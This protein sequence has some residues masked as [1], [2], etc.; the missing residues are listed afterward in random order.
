[1]RPWVAFGL[2]LAH[3]GLYTPH[4]PGRT[5]LP[6]PPG[7]GLSWLTFACPPPAM[8]APG[9]W[10]RVPPPA[11]AAPGCPTA[12]RPTD[13]C[14]TA[15]PGACPISPISLGPAPPAL[16]SAKPALVL[17]H[18]STRYYSCWNPPHH[19]PMITLALHPA[20][21]RLAASAYPTSYPKAQKDWNKLEAEVK[22]RCA[23]PLQTPKRSSWEH[24]RASEVRGPCVP[25]DDVFLWMCT[26]GLPKRTA[27]KW[28]PD[29]DMASP[30]CSVAACLTPTRMRCCWCRNPGDGEEGGDGGRGPVEQLFQKD[31]CTGE[32]LHCCP[33]ATCLSFA[34]W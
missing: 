21:A 33:A 11:M 24:V 29:Q 5:L 6:H 25:G 13:R 32:S 14:L 7:L 4:P 12:E 1:M 15:Y 22:V 3:Q 30:T 26:P 9:C 34:C 31:I 20:L 28:L 17:V 19:P 27:S 2:C 10:L 23:S 8:A 18:R 16:S